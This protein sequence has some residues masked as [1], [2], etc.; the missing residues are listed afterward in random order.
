MFMVASAIPSSSSLVTNDP[1]ISSSSSIAASSASTL[2]YV[3]VKMF[4][5]TI[6]SVGL[7]SSVPGYDMFMVAC[8]VFACVGIVVVISPLFIV[9]GVVVVVPSANVIVIV[10][11]PVGNGISSP[12]MSM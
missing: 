10:A 1:Y 11:S 8:P 12:L 9:V 2:K 4:T 7:Y 3:C 6:A 5:V